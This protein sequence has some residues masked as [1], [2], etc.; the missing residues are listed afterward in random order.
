[1]NLKKPSISLICSVQLTFQDRV[2]H[3]VTSKLTH[4]DYS[5]RASI[6]NKQQFLMQLSIYFECTAL[7]NPDKTP[8]SPLH[9]SVNSNI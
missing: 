9:L 7:A 1:M 5:N 8:Q 3:V 4:D 2:N 6:L